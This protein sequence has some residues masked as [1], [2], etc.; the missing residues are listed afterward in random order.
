MRVATLN[1]EPRAASDLGPLTT[2][3]AAPSTCDMGKE[4]LITGPHNNYWQ[5]GPA[6]TDTACLPDDWV[7][8]GYYRPGVC[9]E[10]YTP[11][12][13][14]TDFNDIGTTTCCPE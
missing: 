14:G 13:V 10:D 6:E 4:Y 7:L 5:L 3:F 12:C 1:V 9:P 8:G 2:A 11:A